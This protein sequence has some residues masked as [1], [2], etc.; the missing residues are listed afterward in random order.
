M[1]EINKPTVKCQEMKMMNRKL[2]E[3]SG[4]GKVESFDREEFLLDTKCGFLIIRGHNLHIKNLDLEQGLAI[5][6]G[7]VN[8]LAYLDAN[9]QD[10][11]K[12]FF[13]R[14]FK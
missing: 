10:K 7:T 5:I 13:R 14:L 3:I 4:V 1:I 12:G 11:S 8:S 6:E 9:V 2:L